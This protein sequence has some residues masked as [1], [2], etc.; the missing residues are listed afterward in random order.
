MLELLEGE[1]DP[2][3]DVPLLRP[4]ARR[5]SLHFHLLFDRMVVELD[6][7]WGLLDP[8]TASPDAARRARAAESLVEHL[9][10]LLERANFRRLS[11]DDVHEALLSAPS[12]AIGLRVDLDDFEQL[13]VYVRGV[14][15]VDEVRSRWLGLKRRSVRVPAYDRV[16]LFAHL[17]SAEALAARGR[18]HPPFEPGSVYLKLFRHIPV[19]DIETLMPNAEV[20]MRPIDRLLLG[21]PAAYGVVHFMA[22]KGGWAA[23]VALGVVLGM[24]QQAG[25]D[26][27]A[28]VGA[29][30]TLGVLG[31]F[32]ARQWD[33]FRSKK[34]TYLQRLSDQ[35]YFRKL[36]NG[37]GVLHH[38]AHVAEH[39]ETREALLAWA[40]LRR[41]GEPL[42]LE[43]LDRRA[44]AW[45]LQHS[46]RAVDFDESD[47]LAKLLELGLVQRDAR[48]WL[49]AVDA[50]AALDLLRD[51]WDG[52]GRA[53][54][55]PCVSA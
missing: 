13:L 32:L 2:A 3:Q 18:K 10:P 47:A 17:A 55:E 39:A 51:R 4:L 36:D 8:E 27:S 41:A 1:A 21:L 53:R 30:I 38:L 34:I 16:C 43:E 15:E 35:L 11:W 44:E 54:E 19:G 49:V 23:L 33:R 9:A 50:A 52:L 28:A 45:L 24:Q 48:G 7:N 6:R 26:G 20:C 25:G 42:T 12:V 29:L 5:L 31:G 37:A 22:Y 40:L 14:C 46:G